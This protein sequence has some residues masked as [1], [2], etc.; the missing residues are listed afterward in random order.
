[1]GVKPV[2]CAILLV[3]GLACSRE[4]DTT[5]TDGAAIYAK[6]CVTCHGSTGKPTEVMVAQLKVRDLTAP[7][8]RATLTPERVRKQVRDGSQNKL[9]PAFGGVLDDAQITAVAAY[10]A[11]PGFLSR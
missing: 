9:M 6:Y 1:M 4:P 2:I 10:V 3:F 11:S 5:T 8:V 7:D